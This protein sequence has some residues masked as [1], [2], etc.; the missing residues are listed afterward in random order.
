MVRTHQIKRSPYTDMGHDDPFGNKIMLNIW[1]KNQKSSVYRLN[2][3][4]SRIW[5]E[6][7]KVKSSYIRWEYLIQQLS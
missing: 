3:A 7:W 4:M 5:K 2:H 1:T 6:I